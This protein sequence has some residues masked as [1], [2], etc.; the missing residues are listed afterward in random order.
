MKIPRKRIA[1]YSLL[2]TFL[3]AIVPLSMA[4]GGLHGTL[5]GLTPI[6]FCIACPTVL[7]VIFL[8]KGLGITGLMSY[9]GIPLFL[10]INFIYWETIYKGFLRFK[11]YLAAKKSGN[12]TS[13]N[14]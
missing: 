12:I 13:N 1:I 10:V 8:F 4:I 9:L 7:L 6:I 3:A 2:L 5:F 11:R 14:S